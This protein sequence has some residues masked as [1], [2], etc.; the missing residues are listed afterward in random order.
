MKPKCVVCT[1]TFDGASFELSLESVGDPDL[2]IS[3]RQTDVTLAVYYYRT[4][5]F[6][7]FA[8]VLRA[9]CARFARTVLNLDVLN[10]DVLNLGVLTDDD[11]SIGT[12]SRCR[13][14]P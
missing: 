1:L 10:L 6:C 3:N 8:P 12:G 11:R 9:F 14:R 7:P 4:R 2:D 5:V 13:R